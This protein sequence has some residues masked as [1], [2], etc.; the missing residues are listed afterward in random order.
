[1]MDYMFGGSWGWGMG[2]TTLLVWGV[3]ILLIVYLWKQI[4]RK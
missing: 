4:N 2:L 3:L 1:M